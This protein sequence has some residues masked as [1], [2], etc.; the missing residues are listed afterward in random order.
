MARP[1][2]LGLDYFPLDVNMDDDVELLEAECGLEGY[3]ILIKLWQKIYSNGYY[4]EW[5]EDVALLFSRKINSNINTVNSVVNTCLRRGIFDKSINEKYGIL[6]SPGIQKRYLIACNQSKRKY[7]RMDKR[8][9]LVNSD[10]TKFITELI[11]FP[12]EE[13]TQRKGKER[14]KKRKREESKVEEEQSA[15]AETKNVFRV[16]EENIHLPTAIEIEKIK[17]W[18]DTFDEDVIIMAI[19]EAVNR[20]ARNMAYINAILNNWENEGLKTKDNVIAFKRDK[21]DKSN[22]KNSKGVTKNNNKLDMDHNYDMDELE[23][24]LLKRSRGG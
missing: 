14:E 24:Q 11:E 13:S 4:M 22:S 21:K 2:K 20:N 7:I 16:F 19:E 1:L 17:S 9:I 6:T 3:A 5:N 10:Y 18:L 15:T 23:K 12:P 8:Y